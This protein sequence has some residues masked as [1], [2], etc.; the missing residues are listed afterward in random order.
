MKVSEL[1]QHFCEYIPGE[2]SEE[3]DNDGFMVGR[4]ENE[5]KKILFSLDVT[6]EALD[7]A[8]KNGFD[9][10]ITHHPL[11]FKPLRALNDCNSVSSL[12]LRAVASGISV[13]SFHTRLDALNGGVNDMLARIIGIENTENVGIM[14]VGNLRVE[15]SFYPF[16]SRLKNLLKQPSLRA[17]KCSDHVHRVAVVGGSGKDFLNDAAAAGAD[18]FIT[19]EMSYN[20]MIEAH[21]LGISV[22]EA[23]HF[24]TENPILSLLEYKAAEFCGN[25]E[26]EIFCCNPVINF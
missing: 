2:L 18:T 11:I 7:Y 1:Y 13:M 14:R 6:G 26:T 10:I 20:C 25:V 23:G 17:V 22:V 9:L 19:G 16:L 24:H 3:W 8:E 12:A 4:G 15:A 5:V 21:E